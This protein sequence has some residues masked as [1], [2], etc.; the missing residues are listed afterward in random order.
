MLINYQILN[1]FEVSTARTI[2]VSGGTNTDLYKSITIPIGL[3]FQP[4]DY[5]DDINRLVL[6]E[7]KKAINPIFDSE[8]I[9]YK[10]LK[11]NDISAN[12]GQGL[13]INFRFWDKLSSSYK[14]DY[15]S[16]GFT[17]IDISRLRN[18]FRKSFFRL[19]FYDSNSGD[20]SNLLFVEDLNVSETEEPKII[21][22]RLYWLR[23]DTFFMK[24]NTNKTI[25]MDARFFNAKTGKTSKFINIPLNINNKI[26]IGQYS[27][28]SNR[29]WLT[30]AIEL[31]NPKNNNGYYNYKT[32]VP[33]GANQESTITL[34][35]LIMD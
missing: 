9:K 27:N 23:N 7:R 33:F 4:T 30:S 19:Y 29:S 26:N 8:T 32:V 34:S 15:K 24:N 5:T 13:I 14:I 2:T 12:N 31:I 3:E 35:E 18:G 25:Y 11:E 28:P 16:N 17:D 22:N 6:E 20:T 10:F 1:T 21:L